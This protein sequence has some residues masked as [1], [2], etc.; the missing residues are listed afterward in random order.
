MM[1]DRKTEEATVKTL[2]AANFNFKKRNKITLVLP[3]SQ[4]NKFCSNS[5][6]KADAEISDRHELQAFTIGIW[7]AAQ[8]MMEVYEPTPELEP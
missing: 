2:N 5:L 1:W 8:L 4:N 3:L 7:L 6:K